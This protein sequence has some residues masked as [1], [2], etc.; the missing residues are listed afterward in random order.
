MALLLSQLNASEYQLLIEEANSF[1]AL[2]VIE[3]EYG[4]MSKEAVQARANWSQQFNALIKLGIPH[5]TISTFN[6][7]Y[8]LNASTGD[9]VIYTLD[10]NNHIHVTM[11]GDNN[12]D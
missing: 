10:D 3:N 6:L 1:N 9:T 11:K 8:S 5:D 2:E 4:I 12:N 7:V